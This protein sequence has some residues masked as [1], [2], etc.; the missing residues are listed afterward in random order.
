MPIRSSSL[1]RN[2]EAGKSTIPTIGKGIPSNKQGIDGDLTFRR[3]SEGLKLYIKANNKWHGI[4]VG[5]SFDSLE[6]K[7]NETISKVNLIKK[8]R[9]PPIYKVDGNFTLNA[10]GDI[11]LNADG[12]DVKI[13]DGTAKHFAFDC[14]NTRMRIFDDTNE[15]DF[16]DI[17]VGANGATSISTVDSDGTSGDLSLSPDG[18]IKLYVEDG[19]A[20]EIQCVVGSNKFASFSAEDGSYSR[21]TMYEHGGSS[22]DDYMKFNVFEHGA[23]T[24]AANDAAAEAA[25]ITL[26]ADGDVI[27]DSATADG[28]S[29]GIRFKSSGTE[30]ARM[31]HHHANTYLYMYENGG[32]STDDFLAI[33]VGASASST[34]QTYDNAG[35]SANFTIQADGDIT[36]NSK[37]GNIICLNDSGVYTPTQDNHVAPKVYVDSTHK[38]HYQI[39]GRFYTRYDNWYFPSTLYGSN[40]NNWSTSFTSSSL[41]S[42]WNDSYNPCIIVPQGM[43]INSYAVYGNFTSS[44]TYEFALLKATPSYT[45]SSNPSFSQVGSTRSQVATSGIYYKLEEIG[46][47]VSCS[48]GDILVPFCRRTT[49]DTSTYYYFECV[50]SI[51]GTLS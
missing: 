41:P 48:A 6:K 1:T 31:N 17:T 33:N 35:T 51:I 30:I 5:E 20:D 34:I 26:D 10:S 39:S 36:L 13:Y 19:G 23:T 4:K 7:I 40:T 44:Q 37:T 3:T 27:L 18:K 32:A 14:N 15:S 46:L 2:L 21:L 16:L 49:T 50:I 47:D 9:L 45:L 29:G 38:W 25:P 11:E 12:G 8:F 42:T 22:S 24:I 43:K 28:A